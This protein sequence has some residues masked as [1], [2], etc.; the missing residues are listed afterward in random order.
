M[1]NMNDNSSK[2][3][4]SYSDE[5]ILSMDSADIEESFAQSS[6]GLGEEE[7]SAEET[8]GAVSEELQDTELEGEDSTFVED[9]GEVETGESTDDPEPDPFSDDQSES[10]EEEP[11]EVEGPEETELDYKAEYEGAL[12]PFKASGRT[13]TPKSMEELRRLAQMGYDYGRKMAGMKPHQK[14]IATLEKNKLM[15]MEDINYL[16]DLRNGKPEAI[17]KLLKENEIDPMDFSDEEGEDYSPTDHSVS[18]QELALNSV[19]DSIK[20]TPEFKTTLTHVSGMDKE[21]KATLQAN[22]MYLKALND[23]VE[24]G[25]Y[26]QINAEVEHQRALGEL[27]GLSDLQAYIRTGDAMHAA[28]RFDTA[29][30]EAPTPTVKSAKPAQDSGSRSPD[31]ESLR[32]R[33]RAAAPTKGKA[34][35]GKPKIDISKLSDE[36]IENLDPATL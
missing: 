1:E 10:E 22:P 19:I 25:Y 28:G 26:D 31:G 27:V 18:D 13:V 12:A 5:E 9:E 29:P 32:S 30:E 35:T 21:S 36:Q 3:L 20:D 4:G 23:H 16:L 15:E 7:Q 8:G 6:V 11:P 14:I 17:K 34:S 33:K 24:Q 2:D